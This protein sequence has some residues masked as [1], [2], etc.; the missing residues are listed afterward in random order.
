MS[1]YLTLRLCIGGEHPP[2]NAVELAR[3]ILIEAQAGDNARVWIGS[4]PIGAGRPMGSAK[5][6]NE[7][8]LDHVGVAN[9]I[10]GRDW[11]AGSLAHDWLVG[12]R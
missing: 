10:H 1:I 9:G 7:R 3:E 2:E 6:E 12:F 8:T 11:G 4:T 5:A